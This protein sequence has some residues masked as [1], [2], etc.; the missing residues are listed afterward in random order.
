MED[1]VTHD[2]DNA[3]VVENIET[4]FDTVKQYSKTNIDLVKLKAADRSAEIIASAV[5]TTVVIMIMIIFFAILSIGIALLLGELL[6]KTYYGFFALAGFYLIT[7]LIFNS[8]KEKWFKT[9][10]ANIIIKKLFK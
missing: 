5:A 9:P 10:V 6:G 1:H 4:L 7:G 8:M 3:T 2:E